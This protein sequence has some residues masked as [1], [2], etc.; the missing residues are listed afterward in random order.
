MLDDRL[1]VAL[2]LVHDVGHLGDLGVEHGLGA[3]EDVAVGLSG[4]VAVVDQ[5]HVGADLSVVAGEELE[6]RRM[7][8]SFTVLNAKG[9][10]AS[11][12]RFSMPLPTPIRSIA[13]SLS[14]AVK[15]EACAS[16]QCAR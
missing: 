12:R 4:V 5:L 6:E 10:I 11:T 8:R 1:G 16:R 14:S 13:K 3:G 15:P 2:D 7:L 9:E